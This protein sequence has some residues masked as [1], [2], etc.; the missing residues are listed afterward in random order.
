MT[1]PRDKVDKRLIN[2]L[3][4]P[5]SRGGGSVGAWWCEECC[6]ESAA[7]QGRAGD[8]LPVRSVKD[9]P[10]EEQ[11]AEQGDGQ[12]NGSFHPR[13]I[14]GARRGADGRGKMAG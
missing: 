10:R 4:S 13:I 9:P 6:E 1:L 12:R 11:H 2:G 14:S 3:S 7:H 5:R 8:N